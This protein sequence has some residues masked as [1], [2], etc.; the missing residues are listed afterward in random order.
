MWV[1]ESPVFA[2]LPQHFLHSSLSLLPSLRTPSPPKVLLAGKPTPLTEPWPAPLLRS[3]RDT[4]ILLFVG[5]RLAVLPGGGAQTRP[6]VQLPGRPWISRFDPKASVLHA[7]AHIPHPG[8]APA[9]P[10]GRIKASSGRRAKRAGA[11]A[12]P[13]R[14]VTPPHC[15]SPLGSL[16]CG[17]F[18]DSSGDTC[19]HSPAALAPGFT[20]DTPL[21]AGLQLTL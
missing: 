1:S 3:C 18:H 14:H 17:H 7:A 21:A 6:P 9:T 12:G 8:A 10:H 19:Q 2:A 15:L 13:S 5:Q 11:A 4:G 20:D 16:W